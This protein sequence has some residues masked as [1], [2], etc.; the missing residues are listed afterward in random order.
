MGCSG[1]I[2]LRHGTAI[3]PCATRNSNRSDALLLPDAF[4]NFGM[5]ER[6]ETDSMGIC[7]STAS[8]LEAPTAET[9]P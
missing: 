4:E 1:S 7:T 8:S 9:F 3:T 6:V 5:T 2:V